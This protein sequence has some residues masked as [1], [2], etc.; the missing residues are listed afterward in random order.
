MPQAVKFN[1]QI[2][3]EYDL[4]GKDSELTDAA[5]Q[6]IGSAYATM[7][8]RKNKGAKFVTVGRDIRTSSERI[9]NALVRGITACGI[10]VIDLGLSPTPMLYYSIIKLKSAG[11]I[12]VTGSHNPVG[13]NGLK[14]NIGEVTIYG[15]EIQ[16]LR[17]MIE[18]SDFDL[19]EAGK[20]GNA[21]EKD[22][23]QTYIDEI[24]SRVKLKRKL[25]IVVDA[26]NGMA[27]EIAPKLLRKLGCEVIPLYCKLDGTFPNHLPDPTQVPFVQDLI[28]LVKSEK[29]DLGLGFDGDV[30][31][32]GV[33][34]E[35]GKIVWADRI[36]M[37]FAREI[38]SR[39]KGAQIIFDVKCSQ[40]LPE[41]IEANGGRPLM[42]KTGHSLSKAKLRETG[43]PISGEM[44]G[45]IFF[46]DRWLGFDDG[47]YVAARFLEILA[48]GNKTV[49]EIMGEFPE[50]F[51]TPEIRLDYSEEKKFEFVEK[52]K[53]EFGSDKGLK[54]IDIDGVRVLYPR[55]W[56]LLRASNTQAKIILRFEAKTAAGLAE[57]KN[58]FMRRLNKFSE[59]K[60][61]LKD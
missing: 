21:T 22:L 59:K 61:E 6:A 7:L 48:A 43:A 34:D 18:N 54:I 52:A 20:E 12:N 10:D 55:G 28:A 9:K 47:F 4:R 13:M 35:N 23:V 2:F 46:K 31:R 38:L 33:I 30:D 27:S 15:G 17:E 42:W 53:K 26:G 36:M 5:V 3:R 49:S 1:P 32:T 39:E 29:A 60:L 51:S 58:D 24:C 57:I 8:R 56:A 37:L 45:H 40:A 19:T 25:K 16:K 14:I 44:S 50:Y 41:V 11:G